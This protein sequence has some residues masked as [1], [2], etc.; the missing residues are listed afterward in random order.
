MA[1][2]TATGKWSEPGVPHKGWTSVN[3]EDLGSPDD[4]CQ[5]CEVQEIRY[6]HY[7]SHPHYGEILGV[8]CICAEHME[9]DYEMPKRRERRLQNSAKKKQR[10]LSRKWRTSAKGNS[11]INVDGFNIVVFKRTNKIWGGKITDKRTGHFI[12]SQ[13]TYTTEKQAKLATFD[14]KTFLKDKHGWG[15]ANQN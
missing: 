5:M 11:Y 13:R 15:S 14:A 1:K 6:V 2:R 10:W 3:V 7:M 4:I 8:G 9:E 12:I